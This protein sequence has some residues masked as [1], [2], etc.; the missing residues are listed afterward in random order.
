MVELC[1]ENLKFFENAY[2]EKIPLYFM[3]KDK[4]HIRTIQSLEFLGDENNI[5]NFIINFKDK[6]ATTRGYPM[7]FF[8]SMIELLK[9][10][11]KNVQEENEALTRSELVSEIVKNIIFIDSDEE[12]RWKN[13]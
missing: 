12:R 5:K 7:H 4:I 2:H 9:S 10:L 11:E 1:K 13:D 8:P 3:S 6:L